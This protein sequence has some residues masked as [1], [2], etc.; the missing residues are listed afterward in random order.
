MVNINM[1]NVPGIQGCQLKIKTTWS[2]LPNKA[3]GSL[4][5][6]VSIKVKLFEILLITDC[7]VWHSFFSYENTKK[8]KAVIRKRPLLQCDERFRGKISSK[9]RILPS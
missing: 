2:I 1:K 8:L 6:G 5:N 7:V 3:I 9:S 4:S